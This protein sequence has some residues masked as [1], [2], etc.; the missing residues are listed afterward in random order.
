MSEPVPPNYYINVIADRWLHAEIRLI[1]FKR[2]IL[3]ESSPQP[4]APLE[5]QPLP[6]SALHNEEFEAIHSSSPRTFNKIH[7]QVFQ[8]LY[9]SDEPGETLFPS[10]RPS[11]AVR[12]PRTCS[13]TLHSLRRGRGSHRSS[14]KG[15]TLHLS[16]SFSVVY[17]ED[18]KVVPSKDIDASS[19]RPRAPSAP[20]ARSSRGY[21][22]IALWQDVSSEAKG[23]STLIC[24]ANAAW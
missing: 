15:K 20:S 14:T 10:R 23:R 2:L 12:S 6:L 18:T 4:T 9:T 21:S 7:T 24:M 11:N 1:S 17:K 19:S 16:R 22:S 13:L 5:L 8:A 3:P